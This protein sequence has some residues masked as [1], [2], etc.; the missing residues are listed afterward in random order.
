MKRRL[1]L[2]SMA[3]AALPGMASTLQPKALLTVS[4]RIGR[5]NNETTDTYDFSEAEFLKLATTSITTGTP[6][7]P[8]SVFVGPLLV[9]VMQAAGVTSGT[10]T[11]K[12]L[13]DYWAP[14]PWGDLVRYGVI[15]AHSQNGQ[16]LN[17]KRWGPLWTIYPRDQNLVALKGPIAESRFIWQVNRIEANS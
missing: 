5:V 11:F 13:N 4:G 14:I 17:N 8:T 15:L 6:W 1:L 7:T 12:T 10:L 3:F 16:R 2:G 9:D